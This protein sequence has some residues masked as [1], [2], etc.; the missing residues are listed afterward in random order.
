MPRKPPNPQ[1]QKSKSLCMI[2][3]CLEVLKIQHRVESERIHVGEVVVKVESIPGL[4]TLRIG[5]TVSVSSAA[6]CGCT[7]RAHSALWAVTEAVGRG[8]PVVFNRGPPPARRAY[9]DDHDRV[10]MRESAFRQSVNPPEEA[11]VRFA[12]WIDSCVRFFF[13]SNQDLCHSLAF[14][15]EDLR[16]YALVWFSNFWTTARLLTPKDESENDKLLYRFLRQRFSQ[17]Y[18]QMKGPRRRN[19]AV[20]KETVRIGL[21]VKYRLGDDG[22]GNL[23][24]QAIRDTEPV[25][26]DK[27]ERRMAEYR[28]RVC[29]LDVSTP[30]KRRAS[31]AALLDRSLAAM[32]HDAMISALTHTHNSPLSCPET[33]KEAGKRLNTHRKSCL[34]CQ[35]ASV[36]PLPLDTPSVEAVEVVVDAVDDF[37]ASEDLCSVEGL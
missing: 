29:Q 30:D 5:N 35:S 19:V 25:L 22:V 7:D 24:L 12:P 27:D 6:M 1:A 37:G 11:F 9:G 36:G 34:S 31:A 18:Q 21:S 10:V 15:K 16:T 4:D 23:V 20:D 28:K 8:R 17:L 32:P 3:S 13:M 33:R 14:G 26:D 2:S